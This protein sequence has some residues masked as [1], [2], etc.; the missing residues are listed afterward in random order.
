MLSELNS[1]SELS[2]TSGQ[3]L[4]QLAEICRC[5]GLDCRWILTVQQIEELKERVHLESFSD[6]EPLL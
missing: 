4:F 6:I 1:Y 5:H 2:L 3:H